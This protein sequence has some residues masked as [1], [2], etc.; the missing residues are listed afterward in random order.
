MPDLFG[1]GGSVPNGR[2]TNGTT[3]APGPVPVTMSQPTSQPGMRTP[4]D[5]MRARNAKEEQRRLQI[6]EEQRRKSAERRAAAAGVVGDENRRVR[7]SL[8]RPEDGQRQVTS[9]TLDGRN[10]TSSGVAPAA[11]SDR[12]SRPV[13]SQTDQSRLQDPGQGRRTV[14][15]QQQ[16]TAPTAAETVNSRARAASLSQNQSRLP[17]SQPMATSTSRRSHT[18]QSQQPQQPIQSQPQ[19]QSQQ[20]KPTHYATATSAAKAEAPLPPPPPPPATQS[21]VAVQSER[22]SKGNAVSAFPHAFERWETLS[23]HWEGL[24]SYWIRRLEQNTEEVRREPLAQQMSRQITDLSAAGANLFHA[25]VELQRLRASSERKFQRWFYETRAEQ[26]RA[27]EVKAELEK[28]MR[29]EHQARAESEQAVEQVNRE[30]QTAD[31]LVSEMRRELQI[32]KEE[33]RRAWEELGRREQEERDRTTS[34]R[35]GRTTIV[36][37]VQV[38]PTQGVSGTSRYAG[39]TQ[40]QDPLTPDERE[41]QYQYQQQQYQGGGQS[42]GDAGQQHYDGSQHLADADQYAQG[43]YNEYAS[44]QAPDMQQTDANLT[45][46]NPPASSS[47]SAAA[48]Y[49]SRTSATTSH[50]V[51]PSIVAS[52][53]AS[54]SGAAAAAPFYR[55]TDTLI[56]ENPPKNMTNATASS[57]SQIPNTL[58]NTA[59]PLPF[60]TASPSRQHRHNNSTT[61]GG[62][63]ETASYVASE[64]PFS[65]GVEDEGGDAAEEEEFEYE[66]DEQGRVRIGPD[67]RAMY[68]RRRRQSRGSA[69]RS[70]DSDDYDVA[71]DLRRE[72]ELARRYGVGRSANANANG[73]SRGGDGA[74]Q[75][76]HLNFN[77]QQQPLPDYFGGG[78]GSGAGVGGDGSGEGGGPGDAN[79]ESI[80]RHRHLTRLSDVLEED[81]RS[82]TSPSRT[83]VASRGRTY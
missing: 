48:A 21:S 34:L 58:A 17:N 8:H 11:S 24:T 41:Q 2:L 16:V 3:R 9:E 1:G 72:Q 4:R 57:S 19:S 65:S 44:R 49:P 45:N 22:Q 35:E 7:T 76:S 23:S 83:S 33:A 75:A 63:Q 43:R 26:E 77:P 82:R 54:S 36:G 10:Y 56:H 66:L 61:G 31:T 39:T 69:I 53:Q 51:Q 74:G 55:H 13:A 27:Q 70:E 20:R 47:S 64:E 52:S 37:G 15:A 46:A 6:E 25:V 18:Q 12:R 79:W 73:N 14:S 80:E 68:R 78:G 29:I 30:K 42:G 81:E 62:D 38:V 40:P 71:E 5:I 28:A 50:A 60:N 59:S 32:S 67:G